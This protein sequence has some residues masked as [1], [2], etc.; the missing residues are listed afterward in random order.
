MSARFTEE[1]RHAVF[2]EALGLI[3]DR[4]IE[5]QGLLAGD[6]PLRNG[7]MHEART[8]RWDPEVLFPG[9]MD[10]DSFF[11][12]VHMLISV[13]AIEN[14]PYTILEA[15]ARGV[16]VLAG[17]VGGVPDLIE[18]GV[19]G[20]LLDPAPDA[21][22]LADALEVVLRDAELMQAWGRAGRER[23]VEMFSPEV[24]VRQHREMM[25]AL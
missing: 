4:G 20:R 10:R 17:A 21:V 15:M 22:Q 3:R 23:L 7:L 6:G 19:T 9:Y 5:V 11:E 25:D 8:Q 14:M 13:S 1:K 2:L 12:R 18:D 24:V 16:P